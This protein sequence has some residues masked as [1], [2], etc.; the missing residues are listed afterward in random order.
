M[1]HEILIVVIISI[2]F[3]EM[4]TASEGSETVIYPLNVFQHRFTMQSEKRDILTAICTDITARRDPFSYEG[5]ELFKVNVDLAEFCNPDTATDIDADQIRDNLIS[6]I[7]GKT[8][9]TAFSGVNI[10]HNPN[11]TILKGILR[12]Q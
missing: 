6:E 11:L 5:I 8:Y 4:I 12:Q 2:N 10:R 3:N 7:S 1:Y 9:N